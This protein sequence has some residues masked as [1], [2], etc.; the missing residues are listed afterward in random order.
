MFSASIDI[1]A[2]IIKR[3]HERNP[4][5]FTLREHIALHHDPYIGDSDSDSYI[6]RTDSE[7]ASEGDASERED[8]Y[9]GK[10]K[11][12]LAFPTSS[13]L[14]ID[15]NVVTQVSGQ[16]SS[17]GSCAQAFAECSVSLSSLDG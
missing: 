1:P 3:A 2:S 15:S 12:E 4:G 17:S 14:L 5:L 7:F 8:D 9:V 11:R 10:P 13:S 16:R 6:S